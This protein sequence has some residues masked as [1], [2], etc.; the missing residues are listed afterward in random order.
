M[1][2]IVILETPK[3]E[4]RPEV[5]EALRVALHYAAMAG[6]A[7]VEITLTDHDCGNILIRSDK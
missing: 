2:G 5:L 3:P 4:S 7:R 1:A 6:F